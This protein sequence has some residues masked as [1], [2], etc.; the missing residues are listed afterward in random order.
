MSSHAKI[1]MRP[2]RNERGFTLVELMVTVAIALF[3]LGGLLTIVQNVRR[4]SLSQ[5]SLAQLQDEQRFAMT[6]ITDAIQSGGYFANPLVD[7]TANFGPAAVPAPTA[8]FQAG[9]AFAGFHTAGAAD[10]VAQDTLATRFMVAPGQGPIL[11]DGTDSSLVAVATTYTIVFSIGGVGG[12]QLLCSVSVNGAAAAAPVP[13]VTGVTAMAVYYGVKRDPTFADYN[14]D[15]YLTWDQMVPNSLLGTN[16]YLSISSIRVVL[17]FANPL[18]GPGQVN[19]PAVITM[20][21]VVEVM[22]RAGLHT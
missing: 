18:A 3:L 13:L 1:L 16:D 19:Q 7:T 4:A 11:C 14:V 2:A 8:A 12:N 15:T 22:A 5:Q 17:S 10:N 21:R 6:V 20:E 9:W